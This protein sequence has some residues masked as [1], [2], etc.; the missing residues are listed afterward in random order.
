MKNINYTKSLVFSL[1]IKSLL[2]FNSCGWSTANEGGKTITA[3]DGYIQDA[4]ITDSLGQV[5]K[6]L[7]KDGQYKF[8]HNPTYPITLKGGT[9]EDTGEALI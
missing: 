4:T 6:Y 7:G 5:A 3:V 8:G 2:L 9:L 1:T